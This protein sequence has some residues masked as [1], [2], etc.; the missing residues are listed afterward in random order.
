MAKLKPCPFCGSDKIEIIDNSSKKYGEDWII[1]C[2]GCHIAV[3]ASNEV[4]L[5]VNLYDLAAAWNRRA[6]D[7][8]D[9]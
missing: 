6:G 8:N 4:L 9:S 1:K 5:P 3:I 2:G 7:A